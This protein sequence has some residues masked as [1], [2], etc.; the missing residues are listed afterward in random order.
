MQGCLSTSILR[1]K[2]EKAGKAISV[3]DLA[4]CKKMKSRGMFSTQ[5]SE[6]MCGIF[7]SRKAIKKLKN[8][9]F[10]FEIMPPH[11]EVKLCPKS[12]VKIWLLGALTTV[13]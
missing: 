12:Q 5:K 1:R 9:P 11:F 2:F 3:S 8:W 7:I 10:L 13:S 6:D 4:D